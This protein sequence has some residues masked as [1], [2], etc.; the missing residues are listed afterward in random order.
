MNPDF[1]AVRRGMIVLTIA[2]NDPH[3]LTA[4]SL[5]IMVRVPVYA[6][7]PTR[8]AWTADL[9]VLSE[10]RYVEVEPV[11]RDTGSR[12]YAYRLTDSGRALARKA[13]TDPRIRL[14]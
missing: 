4:E 9:Q 5:D 6:D 7:D 8:I 2:R 1:D 11:V 3:P 13:F 14:T 12:T 10:A